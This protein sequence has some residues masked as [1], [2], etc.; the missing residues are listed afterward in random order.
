MEEANLNNKIKSFTDLIA[1]QEGHKLVL[2]VYQSSKSWPKEELLG[3]VSQIRRAVVSI[4]S[5]IAEGFSRYI[6]KDKTHFYSIALGSV[7]E[8]QNQLLVARD[9]KYMIKANFDETAEQTI[10]VNKLV[11]GLIKSLKQNNLDT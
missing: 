4:T 11:N 10:V 5:N 3:L 8:V 6:W 2:T 1:W 7:T 9:L